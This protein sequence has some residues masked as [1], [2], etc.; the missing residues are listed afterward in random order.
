MKSLFVCKCS[1]ENKVMTPEG[2]AVNHSLRKVRQNISL[3]GSYVS[4]TNQASVAPS[5]HHQ[6]DLSP[7]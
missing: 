1:M 5:D 7:E 2:L 6:R 3:V 4:V